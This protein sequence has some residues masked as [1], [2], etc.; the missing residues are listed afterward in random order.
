MTDQPRHFVCPSCQALNR[1]PAN[2]PTAEA[3][4]GACHG[5]LFSGQ[6]AEVDEAVLA[7]HTSAN[8]IPVLVDVW[9]PW[10]GPCRSMAPQFARAAGMLEPGMRL[11]KLNADTAPGFVAQH[12]IQ[13]I[14]ALL[15]FHRGQVIGRTAGAMDAARIAAWAAGVAGTA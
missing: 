3:R 6:P 9:A 14:P 7:R 10:C 4:C 8:D 5:P 15:L 2:R 13:G 12:G 11:L 1:V